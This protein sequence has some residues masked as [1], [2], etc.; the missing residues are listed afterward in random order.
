M[1]QEEFDHTTQSS[2]EG[3]FGIHAQGGTGFRFIAP[4]DDGL[5]CGQLLD[6]GEPKRVCSERSPITLELGTTY[7]V[8]KSLE[9]MLEIRLGLEE[10]FGLSSTSAGPKQF[11]FSPGLKI[12]IRDAGL[13]KFFSSLQ[14][15]IDTT[16]YEQAGDT[17]FA[18]R[19]VN[20]LQFDFHRT[21]GVY[22]FFGETIGFSRWFR[23]EMDAGIGMQIR[24]P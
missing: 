17:D 3:Q 5:Y 12:Y 16:D 23:F 11:H 4:Y 24:V 13:T 21:V 19:N 6:D 1:A 2:H 15:A 18:V 14:L 10:D 22:F 20:G 9:L 8:S 7:G